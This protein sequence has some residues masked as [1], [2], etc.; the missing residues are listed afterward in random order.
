[1]S[2]ISIFTI[3][4][5]K[6]DSFKSVNDGKNLESFSTKINFL[7]AFLIIDLEIPPGP[8]TNREKY[9]NHKIRMAK[10]NYPPGPTSQT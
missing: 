1:M 5:F 8:K 9:R 10:I 6:H 4:L 3:V 2:S 7:G